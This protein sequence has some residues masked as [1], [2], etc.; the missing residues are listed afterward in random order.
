MLRSCRCIWEFSSRRAVGRIPRP[1]VPQTS[2]YLSSRSEFSS[3]SK[4]NSPQKPTSVDNGSHSSSVISKVII[5]SAVVGVAAMAAYKAGYIDNQ[6]T[7]KKSSQET[8]K[9]DAAKGLEHSVEQEFP[10]NKKTQS[11]SVSEIEIVHKSDEPESPETESKIEA[12]LEPVPVEKEEVPAEKEEVPLQETLQENK[13][14]EV[15]SETSSEAS[16]SVSNGQITN[17]E[18]SSQDKKLDDVLAYTEVNL[19]QNKVNDTSKEEKG[20]ES[21]AQFSE[22]AGVMNVPMEKPEQDSVNAEEEPQKSLTESYSLQDE[23]SL[24]I[25]REG[26]NTEAVAKFSTNRESATALVMDKESSEAGKIILDLIEAIHVAEKKQVELDA[27]I[28]AEER[29]MLKEKYEKELKDARARAL[30]YAEEAAILEKELNKEKAKATAAIKSLEE[31]AEKVLQEELQRK[32]E[33]ADM[34]LKKVQE[35]AKAELAAAI[36]KEKSSQLEKIA[37]A[38]LNINALCMAFYARSE[39]AH[40]THSIHKLALGTLALEDALSRGLPIQAEVDTLIKSFEGIDKDSLLEVTLS[41][42]PKEILN[43]GTITQMQ[44]NEKFESL[45]GILRHFSLIPAAGGGIL[46]HMVAY[47]A[48]SIKIK[49]EQSGDGIESIISKVENFLMDGN[50]AEAADVLEGGVRGSKAEE[51]V[52]EWV[53]QARNRAIAEQALTLLQSYAMSITFS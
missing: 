39:E 17:S 4:Q 44:L 2:F 14:T 53:R 23:R 31:K 6:F 40:H 13:Q 9:I 32:A 12:I 42:L 11:A 5:G 1:I 29:R 36:A 24:E 20:L 49:E 8:T 38:D 50:F 22:E 33:E 3:A 15:E 19:E 16:L 35:L 30:M 41:S 7:D 51:V 10:P 45:K 25:S 34:Q 37:E 26:V 43:Y 18:V 28:F 27:N 47:I 21:A 48:S 46:T 52:I